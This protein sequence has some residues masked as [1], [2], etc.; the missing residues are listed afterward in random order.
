M[1][2]TSTKNTITVDGT[3]YVRADTVP[4]PTYADSPIRIVVLQ[5]G[6]VAVGRHTVVSD[7]LHQLDNARVIRK[8]GTTKGLGEIAAGGPTKDTV[9]DPAGHIEYHPLAAVLSLACAEGKWDL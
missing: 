2:S 4:A 9:L 3:E 8:W 1:S 6:W 5:R 7:E